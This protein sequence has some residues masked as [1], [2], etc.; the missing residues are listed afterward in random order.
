MSRKEET[1][2]SL[3][4]RLGS[5]LVSFLEEPV[6]QSQISLD[7]RMWRIRT[8]RNGWLTQGG[9]GLM[10]AILETN[11]GCEIKKA[12]CVSGPERQP[13]LRECSEG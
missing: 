2:H 13:V 4:T 8:N 6:D 5:D 9:K 7:S 12:C 10:V 11:S 1:A 3:K